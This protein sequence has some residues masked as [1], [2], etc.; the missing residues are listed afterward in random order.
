MTYLVVN[1]RR[2][3]WSCEVSMPQYRGMPG[4]EVGVGGL[5]NRRGEGTFGG[6][7]RKGDN[8]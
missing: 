4:P 8:I 7:T 5:G 3:P 1:G 6:K 2:Q